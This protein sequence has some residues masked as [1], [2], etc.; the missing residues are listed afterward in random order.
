MCCP[1][2]SAFVPFLS[3]CPVERLCCRHLVGLFSHQS[4]PHLR[5]GNNDWLGLSTIITCRFRVSKL[6]ILVLV[7][8][9]M[10]HTCS[11]KHSSTVTHPQLFPTSRHQ[12][13]PKFHPFIHPS[14][15]I[16]TYEARKEIGLHRTLPTTPDPVLQTEN[17]KQRAGYLKGYKSC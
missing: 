1:F 16:P 6:N 17:V 10:E 5:L 11:R 4:R 8:I 2:H 3:S 14:K 12:P 7:G 15:I 13:I 9:H